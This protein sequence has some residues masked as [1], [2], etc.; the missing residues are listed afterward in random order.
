MLPGLRAD[1]AARWARLR[2]RAMRTLL[3]RFA[4][5]NEFEH[6]VSSQNGEDG[7][8]AEIFRRI[9]TTNRFFVEFG[10]QD[11]SVC[12]TAVL[13]NAGWR[14]VMLEGAAD[15]YAGLAERYH[16]VPGVHTVFAFLTA[17]NIV[18]TFERAG[19]PVEFDLLSIDVDGNDYWLWKAL[20]P[21]RPRVVVIEYN[22]EYAP[23]T[24]WVMRYDPAHRWDKTTYYGA[25]LASLEALGSEL[26]YALVGTELTGVNAFFLRDDVAKTSR[27]RLLDAAH[28]YHAPGYWGI[29]G[30]K[31]HVPRE[32]PFEQM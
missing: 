19:V 13:A 29:H 22:A 24:R 31:G 27:F 11:G 14:G 2:N 8:I 3:R 1:V 16:G 26:G 28:A 15:R 18:D 23:P 20:R 4:G 32:G 7:I 25:S 5:I 10:T 17:E 21:Y 9:G 12:N 6:R 30:Q